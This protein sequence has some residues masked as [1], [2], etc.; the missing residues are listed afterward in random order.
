MK[1]STDHKFNMVPI[2]TNE[3]LTNNL[4]AFSRTEND[5]W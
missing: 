4:A 1:T 3:I 2:K 5:L